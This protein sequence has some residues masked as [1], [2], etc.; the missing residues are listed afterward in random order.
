MRDVLVDYYSVLTAVIAGLFIHDFASLISAYRVSFFVRQRLNASI[1]VMTG[2]A[3]V[4]DP[5]SKP[6]TSV[7]LQSLDSRN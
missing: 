3:Q 6:E 7:F 4:L 5:R 1:D 2:I